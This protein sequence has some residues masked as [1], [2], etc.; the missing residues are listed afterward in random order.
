MYKPCIATDRGHDYK[1]IG[2]TVEGKTRTETKKVIVRSKY[3][4]NKQVSENH[5]DD[6]Q[7]K[8]FIDNDASIGGPKNFILHNAAP[9]SS[10]LENAPGK[11]KTSPVDFIQTVGIFF[12]HF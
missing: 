4:Q 1:N 12:I 9:R 10:C 7:E 2:D 6:K 5:Q 3:F 11:R 8:M